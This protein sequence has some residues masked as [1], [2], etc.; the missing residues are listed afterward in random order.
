MICFK[1]KKK[2]NINF[3]FCGHIVLKT[4]K[5]QLPSTKTPTSSL[6][7]QL[8]GSFTIL[9]KSLNYDHLTDDERKKLKYCLGMLCTAVITTRDTQM[10]ERRVCVCMCVSQWWCFYGCFWQSHCVGVYNMQ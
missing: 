3:Q 4:Q 10:G 7:Y 5:R 8:L 9:K 2:K 6:L 1:L